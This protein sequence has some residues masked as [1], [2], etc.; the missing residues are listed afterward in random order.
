MFYKVFHTANYFIAESYICNVGWQ[1]TQIRL[2]AFQRDVLF[3]VFL[4][5]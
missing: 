2:S 5:R 4:H 1:T 3:L